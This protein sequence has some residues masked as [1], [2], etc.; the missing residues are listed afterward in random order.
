MLKDIIEIQDLY[1]KKDDFEKNLKKK[2]SL[3]LI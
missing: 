1:N 3:F 2:N